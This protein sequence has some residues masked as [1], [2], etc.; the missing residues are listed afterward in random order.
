MNQHTSHPPF[1][2]HS[3]LLLDSRCELGEGPVWNHLD[4]TLYWVDIE[5]GLIHRLDPSMNIHKTIPAG[6][7]IA[8]VVP[9]T[10]GDLLLAL[11]DGL[12]IYNVR[13]TQKTL[14]LNNPENHTSGNRFNDSKCDPT[15]RFWIGTMGD[16]HTAALYRLDPD[17]TLHTMQTG[18]TTSNGLAWSLDKK[19]LY[20]IDT[21]TRKV[22]AY[23]YDQD[24]GSI[25]DG[26]DVITI[27]N[28]MGLPDGCTIDAEGMLWIALWGGYAV[29]RWNPANGEL[30]CKIEVPAKQVTSCTFGGEAL[31]TLYI[32][33]ARR[34][35]S[36]EELLKY[37]HSGGL[38][39]CKPGVKGLK[40]DFFKN[41][42]SIF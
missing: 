38:F 25:S 6:Q 33:T 39:E 21:D 40:A 41:K 5:L 22:V 32:T 26:R 3:R 42:S 1:S 16:E 23:N 15:G 17:L 19:I 24:E 37:P 10:D 27:P 18:V 14:F 13:T 30:L 12:Y 34:Q 11:K 20:Y 9:T 28:E 8:A 7:K 36:E 35:L 31:D 4:H 2:L 29:G